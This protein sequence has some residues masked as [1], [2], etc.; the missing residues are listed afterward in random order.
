M[1]GYRFTI[2]HQFTIKTH[3]IWFIKKKKKSLQRY[4]GKTKQTTCSGW[5]PMFNIVILWKK[6]ILIKF[7][8]MFFFFR[9]IEI[10]NQINDGVENTLIVDIL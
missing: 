2:K 9:A 5:M 4:L 1:G 8:K 7:Y 3:S 10:C 6:L